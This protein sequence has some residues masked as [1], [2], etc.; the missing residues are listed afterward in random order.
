MNLIAP[1]NFLFAGLIGI[2]LGV[3]STFVVTRG[4]SALNINFF[5]KLPPG[6]LDPPHTGGIANAIVGPR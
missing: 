6:S 2:P 4:I 1:L 5:T 3:I